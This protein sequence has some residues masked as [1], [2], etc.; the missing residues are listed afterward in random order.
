[1][2]TALNYLRSKAKLA[3]DRL[4]AAFNNLNFDFYFRKTY[5]FSTPNL[6]IGFSK[7]TPFA[8]WCIDIDLT[9]FF[10][11]FQMNIDNMYKY[12]PKYEKKDG[13]LYTEK[14]RK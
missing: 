8:D 14:L 13:N 7:P 5:M 2:E 9:I 12:Y 11:S 4:L 6:A 1:M 10:W 3:Y